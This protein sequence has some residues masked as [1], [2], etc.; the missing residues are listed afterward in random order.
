MSYEPRTRHVDGSNIR[1]GERTVLTHS[2]VLR[3][4]WLAT[5]T[6]RMA[7]GRTYSIHCVTFR[8]TLG[9]FSFATDPRP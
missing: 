3:C 5:E 6:V 9:T 7:D 8:R 2:M 4:G 1:P